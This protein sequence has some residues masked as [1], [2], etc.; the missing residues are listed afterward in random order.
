MFP[1]QHAN[2][3]DL[4]RRLN[5]L[6]SN[7]GEEPDAARRFGRLRVVPPLGDSAVYNS[8]LSAPLD[9]VYV[10]AE[11]RLGAI[12]VVAETEHLQIAAELIGMLDVP[13]FRTSGGFASIGLANASA[14]LVAGRLQRVI[15]EQREIGALGDDDGLLVE[16]DV[17][18]NAIILSG[19]PPALELARSVLPTLDTASSDVVVETIALVF[20]DP[21]R[22]ADVAQ[23]LLQARSQ[24]RQRMG[25][26]ARAVAE[27]AVVL[28]D[29][30]S[31]SVLVTATQTGL[32]IV[33][34]LVLQLDVE[35]DLN[36]TVFEVIPVG[37]AGLS[38][39]ADAVGRL[40]ERR[41]VGLSTSERARR[42]ALVIPDARTGA[43]LVAAAPEDIEVVQAIT[44]QLLEIPDDPALGLHVVAVPANL[45]VDDVA[46]RIEQLMQERERSLGD[47]AGPD[48]RVV[49]EAERSSNALLVAASQANLEEV[50]YLV[51]LLSSTG[52]QLLRNREVALI[53][54][55]GDTA[56]N[57]VELLE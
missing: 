8:R 56:E 7:S 20:A 6:L 44:D 45:E 46:R 38:R 3:E 35:R 19:S 27:T 26:G 51:E 15:D 11:S 13:S 40:L 16:P 32:E 5:D 53:S 1:V 41:T 14:E 54:V 12:L 43:L 9:E 34:D 24:M 50:E 4:A 39:T 25:A 30:R 2:V 22:V 36:E 17:A 49:V 52:D 23:S 29:L 47:A 18:S 57:M 55:E 48:D 42:Q 37:R 31:N 28:P 10:S 21:V 33:Q